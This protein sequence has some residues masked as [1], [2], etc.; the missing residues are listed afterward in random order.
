VNAAKCLPVELQP[1]AYVINR[2][3]AVEHAQLAAE[4]RVAQHGQTGALRNRLAIQRR[5]RIENR[6]STRINDGSVVDDAGISHHRFQ[7]V[8]EVGVGMQIIRD[9]GAQ[10][11]G[12]VGV[13]PRAG[14]IGHRS[15]GGILQLIG[16]LGS[17]FI[18]PQQALAQ[19]LRQVNPGE[20]DHQRVNS[21]VITNT[22]MNLRVILNAGFSSQKC[23]GRPLR[24]RT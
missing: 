2:G 11:L 5:V 14:Q 20:A 7:H 24:P 21:V 1:D 23:L 18:G 19:Q 8:I 12:I 3:R 9:G 10:R 13:N 6:H 22:M 4:A 17:G 16:E 15:G